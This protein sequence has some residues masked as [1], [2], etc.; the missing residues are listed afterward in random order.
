MK[1]INWERK[2]NFKA[3]T[4]FRCMSRCALSVSLILNS[5]PQTPHICTMSPLWDARWFCQLTLL[6]YTY[7][8]S[9]ATIT[10]NY[11]SH[12]HPMV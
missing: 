8:T 12:I 6:R 10:I 9:T 4:S 3:P 7:K 5:C 11:H 1:F 2:G